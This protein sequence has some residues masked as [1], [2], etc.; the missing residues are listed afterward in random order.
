MICENC[1]REV[2][3]FWKY[4]LS[5]ACSMGCFRNLIRTGK[6]SR[7]HPER[8]YLELGISEPTKQTI[9]IVNRLKKG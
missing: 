9:A 1:G 8:A 3:G 5:H 2:F 6:I 7:I 4:G